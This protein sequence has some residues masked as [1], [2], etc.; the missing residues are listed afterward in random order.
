ML[1]TFVKFPVV[2]FVVL[3]LLFSLVFVLAMQSDSYAEPEFSIEVTPVADALA[4]ASFGSHN[5]YNLMT[6][7][8]GFP[9]SGPSSYAIM[10]FDISTVTAGVAI[11]QARLNVTAIGCLGGGTGAVTVW[12]LNDSIDTWNETSIPTFAVVDAAKGVSAFRGADEG[13]IDGIGDGETGAYYHWTDT[14][15]ADLAVWLES[16]RTINDGTVTL[17]LQLEGTDDNQIFFGDREGSTT[18]CEISQGAPTLQLSGVGDP[19]VVTVQSFSA[20]STDQPQN[21]PIYAGLGLATLATLATLAA[22]ALFV[23]YRRRTLDSV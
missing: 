20:E 11:Q 2:I 13:T 18:G 8:S 23:A 19:L 7:S 16:Q 3:V 5:D 9:S 15:G 17:L 12:G 4:H 14:A 1:K 6:A 22:V 21:R 10:K